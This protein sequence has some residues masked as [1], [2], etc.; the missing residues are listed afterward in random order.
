M[1]CSH[2][3]HGGVSLQDLASEAG[4]YRPCRPVGMQLNRHIW[5]SRAATYS[6]AGLQRSQGGEDA[7]DHHWLGIVRMD[8]EFHCKDGITVNYCVPGIAIVTVFFMFVIPSLKFSR[9]Y[10]EVDI[11]ISTLKIEWIEASKGYKTCLWSLSSNERIRTIHFVG[12]ASKPSSFMIQHCFFVLILWVALGK[13]F[14]CFGP[15]TTQ[16]RR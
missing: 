16:L 3:A 11:F 9:L 12:L 5:A 7:I 2:L 8:D 13:S 6:A 1:S 14:N 15:K 10:S 4:K